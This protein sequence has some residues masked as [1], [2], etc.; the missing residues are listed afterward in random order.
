MCIGYLHSREAQEC[1]TS[2]RI[3][4]WDLCHS[5]FDDLIYSL[6]SICPLLYG[7]LGLTVTLVPNG[8]ILICY[9]PSF[10]SLTTSFWL[11]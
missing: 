10:L 2:K 1:L 3:R 8:H 9:V 4:I 6:P 5:Y 11:D 7:Y